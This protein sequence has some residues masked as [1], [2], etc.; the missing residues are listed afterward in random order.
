MRVCIPALACIVAASLVAPVSRGDAAPDAGRDDVP[1]TRDAGSATSD[2]G[3]TASAARPSHAD[4][5]DVLARL[6]EAHRREDATAIAALHSDA[7]AKNVAAAAQKVFADRNYFALENRIVS[8]WPRAD[9]GLDVEVVQTLRSRRVK[10]SADRRQKTRWIYGLGLVGDAVKIVDTRGAVRPP[11]PASPPW[12]PESWTGRIHVEPS[13]RSRAEGRAK[14]DLTVRVRNGGAEPT[15][16]IWFLLHPFAT[17]PEVRRGEAM[18]ELRRVE[19]SLDAWRVGMPEPVPGG[20]SLDLQVAYAIDEVGLGEMSSIGQ[21]GVRLLPMSGWLP[22]FRLDSP[23]QVVRASHDLVV[24]TPA[25]LSGVLPGRLESVA[26]LAGGRRAWRWLSQ[27]PGGDLCLL[28]GNWRH[29]AITVSEAIRFEAF[30]SPERGSRPRLVDEAAAAARYFEAIAPCPVTSFTLVEGAAPR[31]LAWPQLVAVPDASLSWARDQDKE[32]QPSFFVAHHLAHAWVVDHPASVGIGAEYVREGLCDH[33]ASAWAGAEIDSEL[34]RLYRGSVLGG[35]GEMASADR[36]LVG[37]AEGVP[38]PDVFGSG[39]AMIVF[40]SYRALA[41]DAAWRQAL[42]TWMTGPTGRPITALVEALGA[43]NPILSRFADAFFLRHGFGEARLHDVLL[44]EMSADEIADSGLD[45]DAWKACDIQIENL[46]LGPLP[47]RVAID[48]DGQRIVRD[49]VIH[50]GRV[51]VSLEVAS[52]PRHVRLD[53][54]RVLWTSAS[55]D[56]VW[57]KTKPKP[58]ERFGHVM[59]TGARGESDVDLVNPWR[60]SLPP[61]RRR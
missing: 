20:Q 57:P 50:E 14:V 59:D 28:A 4:A 5:E 60:D 56:D 1:A 32:E 43:G 13:A 51:T 27:V 24:E 39:K 26:E 12:W 42:R 3:P 35:I 61:V 58:K 49:T 9:G 17:H 19:G 29:E 54:D 48:V 30:V 37:N 33:L 11:M 6:A 16:E 15:A 53:P 8:S 21:N 31:L 7:L 45:P 18:L 36:A 34:P 22:L 2:A 47:L 38:Y 44:R 10:E 41:G 52:L 25:G 55:D 40:D 23:D 46:G